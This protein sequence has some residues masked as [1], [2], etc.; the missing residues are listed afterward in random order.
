MVFI[1]KLISAT[2]LTYFTMLRRG[3]DPSNIASCSRLLHAGIIQ[4]PVLAGIKSCQRMVNLGAFP[5]NTVAG[6]NPA[7]QLML[8]VYPMIY[9]VLKN[10][11]GFFSRRISEASTVAFSQN[12]RKIKV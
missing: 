4:L 8:V 6:R 1:I 9:R 3:L 11:P 10:R 5:L 12:T 2:Q 7:S